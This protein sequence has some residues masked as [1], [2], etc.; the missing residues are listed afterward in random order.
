VGNR[1]YRKHQIGRGHVYDEK[2]DGFSLGFH[3][4]DNYSDDGVPI[5]HPT[6][7]LFRAND[8]TNNVNE[9]KI[10]KNPN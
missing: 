5:Q 3:F 6:M 4:V 9:H 7:G 2:F 10:V 8:E 1:E